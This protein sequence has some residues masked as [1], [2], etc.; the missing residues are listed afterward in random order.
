MR[1]EKS[2]LYDEDIVSCSCGFLQFL[3]FRCRIGK[4]IDPGTQSNTF[5]YHSL[6]INN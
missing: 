5:I 6:L 1:F 3:G 4:A 2:A